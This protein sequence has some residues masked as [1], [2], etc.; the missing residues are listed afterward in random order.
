M[1][2][3][4]PSQ[5][6]VVVIGGGVVGC[7]IAYHLTKVGITDVVLCERKALTSGTTWHAAG[8][9]GQ[10]R[11]NRN[12]TELARYTANL[13]FDLEE[14]TG[15]STGYKQNGSLHT[16]L[17]E[18]R[19]EEIKRSASM[20]MSFGLECE[21]LTTG[22]LKERYPLLN[23]DGIVGGAYLPEDGQ[24]NP[25]DTT[26]AFAKGARMGGA[27]IF[28]NTKV[29]RILVENGR[30]V[31]VVTDKGDIRAKTVVIAGGMWSRE[32][33][34]SIGVNLPLHAA[35]HF[36]IVTEPLDDL[37]KDL[38]VLR[39]MD[40]HAYYKEDAGKILLGCFEPDSKPWGMDGIPEDFEFTTLQ[41]DFDHFE[42]I[43][44][45]A[46]NRLPILQEAG[47]ALFFNGPESFTPD[48][49]Y[50]LG[51]S[52]EVPDLFVAC[53]F[54]SIGIQSSGGAGK[55]LAE[56]IRDR[57]PPMD[58]A[59]VDCRRMMHFQSNKN[60]LRDRTTETLGLLYAMHWPAYQF[61]TARGARRTPLHDK[62][63][64]AGAA[65]GEMVGWERPMF[66]AEDGE[67]KEFGY[68]FGR[69]S[70]HDQ[71]GRECRAMA[72][73][74]GLYDQSSFPK[75]LVEGAD[76]CAVL[77]QI[78][79]SDV[80]VPI[81][82]TVYTQ[83][84]NELG[85]IEADLTVTRLTE[86]RFWV[87]TAG[88][89]QVRDFAW[90]QRHIPDD[91]RCVAVDITSGLPMIGLMGPNSR[92]LLESIS[93]ADLSNEA[94]PFGTSQ[95]LELGYAKV[96]ANRLTYVGEL[97]WE[98][99]I[100]AEFAQNVYEAI[101]A[102]G[103]DFGLAHCGYFAMGSCRTEKG[104]RHWGHDIA[105]EDTP[106]EA[107]LG[108]TVG[109]DKADGFLGRDALLRQREQRTQ[110]GALPKRLVQA[111]IDIAPDQAPMLYHEEPIYRDGV[112][113]GATTSGAWGHRIDASI[114]MGYVHSDEGVNKDWLD[115]GTW[116]IEVAWERYPL[117]VQFGSWYDPKSE[118]V[119]S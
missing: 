57:R 37:P 11:P 106:L 72:D 111:K 17:N 82:K 78:C 47:I 46:M 105:D 6:D 40:E 102:A 13:L 10:L 3:S 33:G 76:A 2:A 56:W 90:L 77:N 16:A 88:G 12:M 28:E 110:I 5:A 81:G 61:K 51:E 108:F 27:K 103:P 30:A 59:D 85:G 43:L 32:L 94:F 118:R 62:M 9:V 54:N 109:W 69:P 74:V 7:S 44:E 35:E 96:R 22:D 42:P 21:I 87:V 93:G 36:Y 53:G 18:S 66:F 60:Y 79:C 114:G 84:L 95:E 73:G 100:P 92:A 86:T 45:M 25:I 67:S 38:P 117:S 20:A 119:K 15:Q 19:L 70:W 49:R 98:I 29:T 41:E 115:S 97:G 4:L 68:S 65:M 63:L 71:V 48:D 14:E 91:A 80:D 64:T 39:V 107:G 83:W 52:P 99:Y 8:L 23:T 104:Y 58:L 113:V 50:L 24:T 89:A 26:Q 1:A 55:V 34:G 75:Y 101:A 31:G 112:H 116:E